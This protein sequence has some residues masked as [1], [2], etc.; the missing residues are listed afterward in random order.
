MVFTVQLAVSTSG[1][2][3][4][5]KLFAKFQ[6]PGEYLFRNTILISAIPPDDAGG[7]W[8]VRYV[9]TDD[10]WSSNAENEATLN[11]GTYLVPISNPKGFKATLR[12][13]PS[14]WA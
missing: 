8:K 7:Q 1:Y 4:G 6:I 12:L 11:K 13:T 2:Q 3:V 9:F 14:A 5:D 10:E